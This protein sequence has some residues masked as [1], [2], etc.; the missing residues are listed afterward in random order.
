MKTVL[1][2]SALILNSPKRNKKVPLRVTSDGLF[3]LFI[4]N[5]IP[6]KKNPMYHDVNR[7]RIH[8]TIYRPSSNI[9][10]FVKTVLA[11]VMLG[12]SPISSPSIARRKF[13]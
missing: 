2:F 10:R 12:D 4:L 11:V 3:Y 1:L 5:S 6:M 7:A 13:H 9:V 8:K